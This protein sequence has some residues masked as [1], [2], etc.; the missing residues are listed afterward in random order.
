MPRTPIC[1][2]RIDSKTQMATLATKK[3]KYPPSPF[4]MVI[5][6]KPNLR[7]IWDQQKFMRIQDHV[8]KQLLVPKFNVA[9]LKWPWLTDLGSILHAR[10]KYIYCEPDTEIFKNLRFDY[11][12]I[13][14]Y[15]N[16]TY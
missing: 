13:A 8:T 6:F 16:I 9:P 5:Y 12:F 2:A 4:L 1:P 14:T 11:V 3:G 7:I 15:D 10:W